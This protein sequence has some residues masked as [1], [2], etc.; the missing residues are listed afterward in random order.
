MNHL[1]IFFIVLV[2]AI[3]VCASAYVSVAKFPR[4]DETQT[5]P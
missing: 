3:A 2:A 4:R 5:P 1:L